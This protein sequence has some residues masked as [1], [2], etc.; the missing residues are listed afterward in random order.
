MG[1]WL[2]HLTAQFQ[3]EISSLGSNSQLQPKFGLPSHDGVSRRQQW[4]FTPASG[5][6]KRSL[7]EP[8]Y[9]QAGHE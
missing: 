4:T 1:H 9:K 5:T 2:Q 8:S 3:S 7:A 6:K